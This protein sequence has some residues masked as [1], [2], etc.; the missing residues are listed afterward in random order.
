MTITSPERV[1]WPEVG[2][3]KRDAADYYTA[4]WPA[5]SRRTSTTDRSRSTA[6][7]KASKVRGGT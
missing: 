2:F 7:R 6:F 3:T 5:L 4:V 1:L